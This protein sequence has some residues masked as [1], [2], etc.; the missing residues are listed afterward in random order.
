[1]AVVKGILFED[2]SGKVGNIA[3][4]RGAAGQVARKR[5]KPRNPQTPDQARQR[6]LQSAIA[7]RWPSLDET[8]RQQWN[9]LAKDKTGSNRFGDRLKFS[10]MNLFTAANANARLVGGTANINTPP[11]VTPITPPFIESISASG[12]ITLTGTLPTGYR[13]AAFA[14]KPTSPGR[15]SAALSF[16]GYYSTLGNDNT[17]DITGAYED[18]FGAWP[19]GKKVFVELALISPTTGARFRMGRAMAVTA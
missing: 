12:I 4:Q 7:S 8:E 14:S 3:G 11:Q 9:E 13:V 15:N 10:G 16:I 2:V 17:I 18:K 19:S 1:M 5:V 6:A